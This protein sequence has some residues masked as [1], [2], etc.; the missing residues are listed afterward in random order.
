MVHRPGNSQTTL[1]PP[2]ETPEREVPA[3]L[4]RDDH[5]LTLLARALDQA[6]GLIAGSGPE[7]AH[8]PTPCRSWTVAHLVGHLVSDLTNFATAVSGGQPDWSRPAAGIDNDWAGAFAAARRGLDE[9]WSSAD[10]QA[11]VPT[12]GGGSAPV[13]SRADQQIAEFA[14]HAWDIARATGQSE[15]LDAGVA[16]YGLQWAR[17]NLSPQFRGPEDEGKSFGPEVPVPDD[18]PAYERLAGWFGRDPRWSGGTG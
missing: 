8:L 4:S 10:L 11:Q 7:Q 5:P 3:D 18:A 15:D 14:V 1:A 6:G 12:M 2:P 16:E 13:L 9:A 17:R